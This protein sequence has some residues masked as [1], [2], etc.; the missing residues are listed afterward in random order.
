MVC[1]HAKL[2]SLIEVDRDPDELAAVITE[3][4]HQH[5]A[6]YLAT[7]SPPVDTETAVSS[8]LLGSPLLGT[9]TRVAADWCHAWSLLGQWLGWVT[10]PVPATGV[11]PRH[12]HL[13][14]ILD[15]YKGRQPNFHKWARPAYE[16]GALPTLS[17]L[18]G[19]VN[20]RVL[21]GDKLYQA[22]EIEPGYMRPIILHGFGTSAKKRMNLHNMVGCPFLQ[23]Y[24]AQLNGSR[25]GCTPTFCPSL[26]D[27]CMPNYHHRLDKSTVGCPAGIMGARRN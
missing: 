2:A 9:R 7:T 13:K 17:I 8:G 23:R 10:F 16:Q 12:G 20:I 4:Y 1:V 15:G 18:P 21:P 22:M 25:S 26:D 27:G 19:E 11:W 6:D 24:L 5:V 3:A 14:G